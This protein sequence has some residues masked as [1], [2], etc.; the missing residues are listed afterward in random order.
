MTNGRSPST[1]ASSLSSSPTFCCE[2]DIEGWFYLTF[3][4]VQR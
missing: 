1:S 3:V 4:G 2:V